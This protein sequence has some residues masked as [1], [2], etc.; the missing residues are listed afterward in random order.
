MRLS[1]DCLR[2]VISYLD[3]SGLLAAAQTSVEFYNVSMLVPNW[4]RASFHT[5]P[6]LGGGNMAV[7]FEG[8]SVDKTSWRIAERRYN[9]NPRNLVLDCNQKN[10]SVRYIWKVERWSEIEVGERFTSPPFIV[11]DVSFQIL[12]YPAGNPDT[13]GGQHEGSVAM[14]LTGER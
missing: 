14:Y 6:E 8:T 1:T 5:F 13:A 11:G 4:R 3:T 2:H 10:R 9:N 7:S 12:C